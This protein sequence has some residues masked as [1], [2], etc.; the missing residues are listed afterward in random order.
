VLA[1]DGSGFD[2]SAVSHP[3][4]IKD[5][6]TYVMYYTGWNGST[7]SVGC[8]TSTSASFSSVTR[9]ACTVLAGTASTFDAAGIKD[10]V[11][12]K[13]ASGDYRM[14]YTG[15]ESTLDGPIERVGYATSADG[16][17]WT[18]QGLVLNPSQQPYGEDE[19]GVEPT[20]MLLNGTTLHVYTSG[21]DRTGRTRGDHETTAYPT[22]GS[23]TAGV[24]NAWATYQ[25][26]DASTTVRDFRSITRASS[27]GAVTLWMS[28]L[29]PYSSAGNEFWSAYFPVTLSNPTEALNFLLTVRGVRWQARLSEPSG[30][31]SLDNVAISHA[32]VSFSP[33]GSA[34]TT[35]ISP[36]PGQPIS[37]WG[38]L[39]VNTTL[40]SPAGG[41][42]GG[43]TVTVRDSSSGAPL[44]TQALS[45]GGDT[46]LSL[47]GVAPAAH[48]ALRIT[49]DLTSDGSATPLVRSLK[50]L[51]NAGAKPAPALTL[52]TPTPVITFGQQA[53]LIGSLSQ[54]GTP[55]ASQTVSLLQQPAGASAF[56][57][58]ASPTTDAGGSYQMQVSPNVTTT[59]GAGYTGVS[60][61]PTV[62]IAVRH[63]VS[64][65]AVRK[66]SKGLF[67]GKLAPVEPRHPIQI[68][69]LSSGAWVP[70]AA[71]STSST[72]TFKLTKVIKTC[73]R[74]TFKA[75]APA[76]AQHQAGE[77]APLQVEHHRLTLNVAVRSWRATFT[78][79]VAP[80]HPGK[81]VLIQVKNGIRF[82]TFAKV[83]LSKRSTFTLI[84]RLK[85][86]RHTFRASLPTDRCHFGGVSRARA[87]SVK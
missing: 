2:T 84:K 38:D 76:D 44:A 22:P 30:A 67:S 83:K 11:V 86:G 28:F 78:G 7:P 32:P 52:T 3:S 57:P 27:G 61:N 42:S 66:G 5:G 56:A 87:V 31:P 82:V 68:M 85:R 69:R 53:T 20:G 16:L 39:I 41:G 26:G 6:S 9:D 45:T 29:Q 62:S 17:N 8:A 58:L 80:T 23:P 73:Q 60:T 55:L 35:D 43:G 64:F 65:K 10:P 79:K 46:T 81:V 37:A 14:L 24:P 75:V 15:L 34:T 51:Y 18:K 50:V 59:Y 49:L 40:F 19:I 1:A 54:A 47:A 13:V 48:P 36:P 4:V 63:L 21:I 74:Y 12:I 71:T 33:A 77:S 25:L 72:S 70:F